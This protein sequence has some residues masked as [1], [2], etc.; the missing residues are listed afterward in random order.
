[1]PQDVFKILRGLELN[2]VGPDP[3]TN[4][5]EG[6]FISFRDISADDKLDVNNKYMV[7]PVV[8]KNSNTWYVIF[9][10]KNKI[11]TE[12]VLSDELKKSYEDAQSKLTNKDGNPTSHYEAYLYY[13]DEW[14]TKKMELNKAYADA[15]TNPIK[16][17][18]WPID[19]I[20]YQNNVDQVMDK[21]VTLGFKHE[22]ENALDT[23]KAHGISTKPISSN[24]LKKA[25]EDIESKLM[26]KDGN[27]TPHYQAYMK[28]KDEWKN[29]VNTN[30]AD[31]AMDRWISLGFKEEIENALATLATLGTD[32]DIALVFINSGVRR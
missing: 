9:T 23:L 22:I 24:D 11:L 7:M 8:N 18:N 14:N 12:P 21:W 19:E 2:V 27:P 3:T 28:Y 26:D 6:Y 1:M 20:P 30:D 15:L 31:E 5:I 16:L 13:Q 17:Q 25:C 4:K 10:G 29:K 32:P